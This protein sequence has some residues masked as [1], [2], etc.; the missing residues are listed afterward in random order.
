MI[1]RSDGTGRLMWSIDGSFAVHE[2]FRSHTGITLTMGQGA[3][4]SASTKQKINTR[5]STETEIV[6][7]DDGI[8]PVIW[9]VYF[10]QYQ[11]YRI[12]ENIIYQDNKS[13]ILMENNGRAS[14]GK[15]S[16]HMNI[17]YFFIADLVK[18]GLVNTVQPMR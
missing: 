5:S 2:D 17:K 7:V 14:A 15:R 13:A 11:G 3:I 9:T 10:M 18:R 8:G 1:L 12:K 16:R 6:S 4:T